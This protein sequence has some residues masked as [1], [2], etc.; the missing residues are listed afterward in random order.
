MA[1]RQIHEV[2]PANVGGSLFC[3]AVSFRGM[4]IQKVNMVTFSFRASMCI[5]FVLEFPLLI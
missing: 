4:N 2:P 1:G 3:I 5:K